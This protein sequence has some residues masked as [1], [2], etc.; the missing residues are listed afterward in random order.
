MPN[1]AKEINS[2]DRDFVALDLPSALNNECMFSDM[3][4]QNDW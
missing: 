3:G 1:G 4:S 2:N